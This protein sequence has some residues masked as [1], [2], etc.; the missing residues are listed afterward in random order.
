MIVHLRDSYVNETPKEIVERIKNQTLT[1]VYA[2]ELF[3]FDEGD[4]SDKNLKELLRVSDVGLCVVHKRTSTM[5]MPKDYT[6]N[7][8]MK[9]NVC[10]YQI[11][12]VENANNL[13][14]YLLEVA[15]PQ[16]IKELKEEKAKWEKRVENADKTIKKLQERLKDGNIDIETTELW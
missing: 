1:Q 6:K 12:T 3:F 5:N 15:Y 14:K 7:R 2:G 13:K 4:T 10:S 9:V 8:Y 11:C 16:R